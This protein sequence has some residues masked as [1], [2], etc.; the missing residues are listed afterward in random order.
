MSICSLV[1]QTKPESIGSVTECLGEMEGVEI[2]ATSD[3]G[4]LVV[5][6]DHPDRQVCSNNIMALQNVTGVLSASL[7]YEHFE[8]SEPTPKEVTK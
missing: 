7:V 6:V 4:K 3:E 1:V 8:E 5:T 2:H